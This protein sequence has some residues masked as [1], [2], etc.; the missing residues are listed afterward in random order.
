MRSGGCAG[1]G[2]ALR[3]DPFGLPVRF[4]ASDAAAD[5]R[6][7][8]VELH[9]ERVVLRRSLHGMRMALNM[10]VASYNGISL[11]LMP[12]QGGAEDVLAVVLEH[13][14]PALALPLFLTSRSD[15]ALAE[16]RAWGQLLGV[17]LLLADQSAAAQPGHMGHVRIERPR[18]RRRRRSP[19]KNRRPSILLRRGHGKLT[20][21]TPI[22]R[23]EREIIARN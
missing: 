1:S 12:G 6:M 10:P 20:R 7:R 11:R 19:L 5:G 14:D 9:R 23:G 21:A 18:P 2:R 8:E 13:S 15:E 16:W 22:H 17:P 4:S 3:L